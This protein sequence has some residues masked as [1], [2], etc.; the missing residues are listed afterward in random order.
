MGQKRSSKSRSYLAIAITYVTNKSLTL[1][2]VRATD[3][4][5]GDR[6]AEHGEGERQSKS[7][8]FHLGLPVGSLSY[9]VRR[10]RGVGY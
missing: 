9:L 5:D 10:R 4:G 8:L 6:T 7:D 1:G 3:G 2:D